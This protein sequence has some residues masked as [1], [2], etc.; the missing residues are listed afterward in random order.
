[1]A[2]LNEFDKRLQYDRANPVHCFKLFVSAPKRWVAE[3][4]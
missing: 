1:M 2:L 4:R 3:L